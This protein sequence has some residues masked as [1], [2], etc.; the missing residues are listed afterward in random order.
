MNS[1]RIL[2]LTKLSLILCALLVASASVFAQTVN[3]NVMPGTDWSKYHTYRWVTISGAEQTDPILDAQIKQSIDSQLAAKGF[4][5]S[6][7][8]TADLDVA[9]QAAIKQQQQLNA[10]GTGGG[11]RFGGGMA[12][13]TQTT[14]NIGTLT[15]DAYDETA[16]TMI[17]RGSVTKT[18]NPPKDQS[19]KLQNL[20]KA[21]AKLLQNFGPPAAKK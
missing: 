19:K 17:W 15:F 18:L 14:I 9:Y 6:T 21:M 3:Y 10:Y 12:T 5:K 20:D 13:V 1:E 7:T 2:R 8:A 11:W 4:V 16:Q